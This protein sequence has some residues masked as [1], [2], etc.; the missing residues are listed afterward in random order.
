MT[1]AELARAAEMQP[2]N[3]R[4]MLMST[5]ASPRLGS[6]MRLLPPLHCRVGPAGARTADELVAFLD[7]ERQCQERTWEQL[8]VPIGQDIG[9]TSASLSRPDRLS[10]DVVTRLADALHIDL[11]L[12]DDPAS[13]PPRKRPGRRSTAQEAGAMAFAPRPAAPAVPGR[14][15]P[16]YEAETASA[17]RPAATSAAT[18]PAPG[19]AG[20]S[21]PPPAWPLQVAPA[22]PRTG[23]GLAPL[24]PPRLGRY[25]TAPPVAVPSRSPSTWAPPEPSHAL[26]VAILS[27]LAEVTSEDWS[28]GFTAAVQTLASGLSLPVRFI[29]K[30]GRTT[31]D[32][33]Q[34]FRRKPRDGSPHD[35]GPPPGCFDA[36]DA[37]PLLQ[38][39]QA[40]RQ[41]G[42]RTNDTWL[43][44]DPLGVRALNVALDGETFVQLRLAPHGHP[45]RITA[46]IRVPKDGPETMH[47]EGEVALTMKIGG[48][49]RSFTHVRAGPVFGELAIGG[50]TYLVAAIS[51][52]LAVI[53]V[54]A[55]TA[56]VIWGGRAAVLPELDIELQMPETATPAPA[57]PAHPAADERARETAAELAA[58][59][60][61]LAH[62]RCAR[63]A[64]EKELATAR[65]KLVALEKEIRAEATRQAEARAKAEKQVALAGEMLGKWIEAYAHK[66]QECQEALE[67]RQA[68][69]ERAAQA[70]AARDTRVGDPA[71]I[72]ALSR[73]NELLASEVQR[74]NDA[75]QLAVALAA[76]LTALEAENV[77]AGHAAA[78]R[79]AAEHA[80]ARLAERLL[81]VENE[82]ADLRNAQADDA[83]HL[84][85]LLE[86]NHI[87]EAITFFARRVLG[88]PVEDVDEALDV[89]EQQSGQTKP[90]PAALTIPSA[91][92]A[93]QSSPSPTHTKIGRN[94]P[95]PCGSGK[96]YKRCC[97][98]ATLTPEG[99]ATLAIS[100]DQRLWVDPAAAGVNAPTSASE[101][102]RCYQRLRK[103][104]LLRT[105][106]AS[107]PL[108]ESASRWAGKKS[109]GPS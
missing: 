68:A 40:S 74:A 65:A 45:H 56:R 50:R 36:L 55:D 97:W 6:V 108:E 22:R 15:A 89:L 103:D 105:T 20:T 63:E 30:L 7:A 16:A 12:V 47:L 3:L 95:C 104:G 1:L 88:A 99:E 87:P 75:E 109:R 72:S 77:A 34:R 96:K 102:H 107:V 73:A 82:L 49:P 9:K 38:V 11:E 31:F 62:E 101:P 39:W 28:D 58:E 70:E 69:E 71:V 26:E 44:Y 61:A 21:S 52:L 66:N 54:H 79:D 18:R 81:A 98:I 67:Q 86:S 14:S 92:L 60:S 83:A 90:E 85:S 46:I 33:L 10:L 2:G 51:S 59:R 93:V 19:G 76:K 94:E 29:E 8:L 32:A 53:E 57:E 24:C 42:Y 37:M 5:T 106:L 27:R 80:R 17:S 41:P 100:D 78:Q 48:E 13:P 84:T 64:A 4:R 35:P 23:L 43:K 25:Q 91:S